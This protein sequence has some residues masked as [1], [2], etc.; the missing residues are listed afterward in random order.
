MKMQHSKSFEKRQSQGDL[1]GTTSN[2][3]N[4]IIAKQHVLYD[5]DIF[6]EENKMK[7]K[8][9]HSVRTVLNSKRKIIETEAKSISLTHTYMTSDPNTYIHDL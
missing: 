4:P 7:N 6:M 2:L 3:I 1:K 9:Y 8:K 5:K